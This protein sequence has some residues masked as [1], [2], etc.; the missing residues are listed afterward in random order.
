M[1]TL[2]RSLIARLITGA[3]VLT[4]AG[5]AI[6]ETPVKGPQVA[7]NT[8]AKA[9][10]KGGMGQNGA[11]KGNKLMYT[12]YF[13][14]ATEA[15]VHGYEK[16]TK[17]RIVSLE[18]GGTVWEGVVGPGETKLVP[19]GRGVFGFLS[20]KKA[21]I[22]VGTPSSCAVAGYWGRD[23]NGS[24][25]SNHFY[26]QLPSST[27]GLNAKVI[28]WA[29]DDV[30]LQVTALGK[31]KQLAEQTIKAG[32][33]YEMDRAALDALG[34][35]ETLDIRADKNAISV[36]VYYDQGF[37]VPG[38]DGRMAGK[39]FRTFVGDITQGSNDLQLITYNVPSKITV[40]DLKSGEEIWKGTVEAHKIHRINLTNRYVQVTSEQEI[41]VAVAPYDGWPNY[42]EHHFAGGMEGTGIETEFTLS[43]P[44]ELWLFSY[45]NDN[46]IRVTNEAGVEVWKGKLGPGQAAGLTPGMGV[47]HVKSS[48]GISVM[49]GASSCGAEYSPAAGMFAVD[50]ALLK[51][52]MELKEERR[53]AAVAQ[54][55]TI[56]EAELAAPLTKEEAKKAAKKVNDYNAARKSAAG[57][58]PA[59]NAPTISADEAADRASQMVT[60]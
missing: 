15:V 13:Y 59:A 7:V 8:P 27:S 18:K 58:A 26:T 3:L 48:K 49:G 29:W 41:G 33:Y 28:V 23:V 42:A 39:L 47:Y 60:Y 4:T 38:Q 12:T 52:V 5:S 32:Q 34:V 43:T 6:A 16:D 46:P 20:D 35:S 10:D 17:V 40:K 2:N 54:G 19:T 1:S 44:G 37:F 24:Q 51:V 14:T 22:L 25:R 57:P 21:N 53:Q 9:E 55:R 56:T 31:D 50:E 11:F 30:K 45:Y 36:Q